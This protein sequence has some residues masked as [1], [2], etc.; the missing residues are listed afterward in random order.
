MTVEQL[1]HT[2]FNVVSKAVK[3][4]LVEDYAV[5][6]ILLAYRANSFE[7]SRLSLHRLRHP[8]SQIHK[9]SWIFAQYAFQL[10]IVCGG[11]HVPIVKRW[12]DA[13]VR[14]YSWSSGGQRIF[15]VLTMLECM[16]IRIS[17]SSFGGSSPIGRC[18]SSLDNPT[19]IHKYY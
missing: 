5:L 11:S 13:I 7:C 2:V 17:P 10:G 4:R 19:F 14:V 16:S 6:L 8:L 1:A 18:W 3:Q 12:L 15:I 9:I